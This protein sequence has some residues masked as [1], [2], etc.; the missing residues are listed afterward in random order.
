M[1]CRDRT[2]RRWA[3][4]LRDGLPT[5][6]WLAV[7]FAVGVFLC[8]PAVAQEPLTCGEPAFGFLSGGD[9]DV[10]R[11]DVAAGTV[12]FL[13]GSF[14]SGPG[15]TLRIRVTGPGVDVETCS[16]VANFEAQ[17][18][19]L[20]VEV[21]PCFADEGGDYILNMHVVSASVDHC[22]FPLRCGATPDG[23]GL[24]E[25]GEVDSFSLPG[26]AGGEIE[27]RLTDVDE[28]VDPYL[29]R[30]FNP[31]GE[32]VARV[33][34][35][36]AVF[37]TTS[38]AAY[39]VLIS[40]CGDLELGD[41]RLERFDRRCP[42]GPVITS[43]AFLPEDREFIF[44]AD[45]DE[46]GRPIYESEGNG[47][48][49]VEGR[50]GRSLRGIGDSSFAPGEL[51]PFQAIV[52]RPL[53][54]G[55]A[56]VC[57]V[58]SGGG[59]PATTPF[60]FRGDPISIGRINDL[61]CRFDNGAGEALGRRDPLNSCVRASFSFVDPTTDIQFCADFG[62]SLVFPPG[63]TV[64][65]SRMTDLVG[66]TGAPR[67]IVVRVPQPTPPTPT[68][69]IPATATPTRTR[70]PTIPPTREPGPCTCD[71]DTSGQVRISELTRCVRIALGTSPI[72]QC[73]AGDRDMDGRVVI[74]EL[75]EGVNNALVGCP[76]TPV[77]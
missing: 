7:L 20:T 27:L 9:V 24:T 19:S 56:A 33:C 45:Y 23:I 50:V 49:I 47:T 55:S 29:M 16:N 46:Q 62:A 15:G 5:V 30:I 68:R 6:P 64:V 73:M 53:G 77:D 34:S 75:I 21:S 40:A 48:L 43:M 72:T 54:D 38:G 35:D 28:R 70:T 31:D 37:S 66:V 26:V 58:D 36:T 41:Y 1:G 42:T 59:V 74:G 63:D 76:P 12:G 25:L 18:G 51:P 44:P 10:Y 8:G 52:A 2:T 65:S 4:G 71:C 3:L 60:G 14:T 61:G 17:G 11:I 69:T 32:Q 57:D 13:Q 67:E 22:G 39:T